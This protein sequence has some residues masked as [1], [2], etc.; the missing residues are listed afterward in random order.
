LEAQKQFGEIEGSG[1]FLFAMHNLKTA[2]ASENPNYFKLGF[3]IKT[4]IA[5]NLQAE[6]NL[7][8]YLARHSNSSTFGRLY[9]KIGFT[10]TPVKNWT[11]FAQFTAEVQQSS[12]FGVVDQLPFVDNNVTVHHQD[13]KADFILGAR[14][15]LMNNIRAQVSV[16]Y[17]RIREYPIFVETLNS[18]IWNVGYGGMTSIVSLES[19]ALYTITDNDLFTGT[20]TIQNASNDILDAEVPY[21]PS[22][23]LSAFYQHRFSKRLMT[24]ASMSWMGHQANLNSSAPVYSSV[25][26]HL[27]LNA[28]AEYGIMEYVRIFLN[29]SNILNQQYE[30]WNRY[31]ELPFMMAAGIVLQW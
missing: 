22:M 21:I 3:G 27:L 23:V 4:D 17:R 20:L 2:S 28:K 25:G 30:Q 7:T 26:P 13:V 1:S 31:R 9:P 24:E 6:M 5:T 12:L 14:T 16:R 8:G 19:E 18:G 10:L 15:Q 29:M 11:A